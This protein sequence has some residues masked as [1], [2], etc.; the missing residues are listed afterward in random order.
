MHTLGVVRIG[1]QCS[2]PPF[3]PPPTGSRPLTQSS[4]LGGFSSEGGSDWCVLVRFV[5]SLLEV[6]VSNEL[7]Y[8]GCVSGGGG[9]GC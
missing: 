2:A 3:S 1:L 8:R 7:V 4:M 5:L 6:L 9:D